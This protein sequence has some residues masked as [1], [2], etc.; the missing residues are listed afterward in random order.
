MNLN[1]KKIE[2][3]RKLIK[4]DDRELLYAV[5]RL[6][7]PEKKVIEIKDEIVENPKED[8]KARI[9][10]IESNPHRF[11]TKSMLEDILYKKKS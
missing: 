9:D 7:N 4:V 10:T 6:L 5:E 3:M 11:I 2:I 8:V 1:T